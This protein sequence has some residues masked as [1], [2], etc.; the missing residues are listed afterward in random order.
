EL[1]SFP[2]RRS[3]ALLVA[4][5]ATVVGKTVTDELAY[6][7]GG[8]NEH[9]PPPVNPAALDR[10][11]GGSSSGSASAVAAGVVDL[12]LGTDTGGSIRVPARHC[13]NLG[14]GAAHGAGS[15]GDRESGRAGAGV[16]C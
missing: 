12:A 15:A 5:G 4:A 11:T 10:T 2:T 3:S 1:R 13:G 16:G 7:L 6:S 14:G 8:D 9:F